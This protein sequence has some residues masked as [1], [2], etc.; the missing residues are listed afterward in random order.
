MSNIGLLAAGVLAVVGIVFA[1]YVIV[2]RGDVG[3]AV[4]R[5]TNRSVGL[6]SGALGSFM[7]A[8]TIGL[9]AVLQAPELLITLLGVGAIVAGISWEVFAATAFVTYLVGEVVGGAR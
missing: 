2:L 4:E 7:L 6:V 5:T 1:G 9:E 8:L 3:T